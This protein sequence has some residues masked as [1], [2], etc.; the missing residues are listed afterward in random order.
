MRTLAAE[1]LLVVSLL[2]AAATVFAGSRSGGNCAVNDT[3][4]GG[5]QCATSASYRADG[6]IGGIGG[7]TIAEYPRQMLK[8]GF[9]GQ[10]TEVTNFVATAAPGAA[11]EGGNAQLG[12][13][14]GLDDATVTVLVGN[15]IVWSAPVY[16]V[17]AIGADGLATVAIVYANTQAVVTGSYLAV[18]GW[19]TFLVLDTDPDN[20]GIYAGDQV[21]DWWQ[22]RY[23]GTNNPLGVAGATNVS[24][25]NNRYTYTA[26]LDP[27]NPASVFE[28]VAVSNQPPS[29]VIGFRTTS[30]GRVYRLLY[31]TNLVSGVWTNLPGQ[32]PT[33][34]LA[35]RMSLS[36][37]NAAAVRFYRVQ[38]QLP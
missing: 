8:A 26:D 36:D 14:A 28:I 10:L 13:I 4:D 20:Y 18:S 30:T 34:G 37:T 24:G 16:P 5:G 35:D 38:V 32:T 17:G 23:F 15:E 2:G 29:R 25:H 31:A 12:G 21:P 22:V 7:V 3:L 19:G 27:T 1:M 11:N 33:S 9:V 6:S